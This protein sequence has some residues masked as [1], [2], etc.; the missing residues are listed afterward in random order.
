MNPKV[1]A[2]MDQYDAHVTAT[3][4]R[5]GWSIQYVGGGI[6]SRP[7]CRCEG[8]EGPPF[9]YTTGMFGLNHPEFLI[10]DV[11]P[12][13]AVEVLN[14]VG[15]HV[16]EGEAFLPGMTIELDVWDRQI[17][18]EDVP[19]PGDIVL[20]ANDFYRRPPEAS[21]PV[22]QLTHADEDGRFPW[23]EGCASDQPRP[24]EFRA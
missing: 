4:R 20:V 8:D 11:A 21:V 1:Q 17:L 5:F 13:T 15:D 18:I 9:A 19:N 22:I 10:F 23:E 24:G 16:R 12:E 7:G 2:W 6:C 3:I 14:E